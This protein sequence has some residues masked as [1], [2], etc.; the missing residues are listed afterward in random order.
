M[1]KEIIDLYPSEDFLM[2]DGFDD[3]VI[4]LSE[5]FNK[6]LRLI[7]SVSKC[8]KILEKNMSESDAME[9][10]NFNLSGCYVGKKTP[11]WCWDNFKS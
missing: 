1:I 8:L 5:D 7:Y 4:G 6:P 11:V 2:V 9:Y 10:F 3:A